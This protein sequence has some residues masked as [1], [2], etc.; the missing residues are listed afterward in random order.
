MA[1]ANRARSRLCGSKVM[2]VVSCRSIPVRRCRTA[3]SGE[4]NRPTWQSGRDTSCQEGRKVAGA[5]PA[6]RCTRR[7]LPCA[8]CD[9]SFAA[10]IEVGHMLQ[11]LDQRGVV[12]AAAAESRAGAEDLLGIGG[13]GQVQ[14][15]LAGTG[16]RQ[17]EVLLVQA[18]AEARIEGAFDHA[19][20]VHF[21]DLR[22]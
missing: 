6:Y 20:T 13:V 21:E 19:L 7:T 11:A 2:L 16:Q 4:W 1:V 17:V 14:A 5:S 3:A 15:Q 12:P 8:V 18:D 22:A 9:D 10:D